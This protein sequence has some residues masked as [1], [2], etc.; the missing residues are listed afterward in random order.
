MATIAVQ[1]PGTT[2]NNR[3]S[4]RPLSVVPPAART[5]AR[6]RLSRRGR[7]LAVVVLALALLAGV[8]LGR[9]AISAEPSGATAAPSTT[10]VQP[11]DTLWSLSRRVAPDHDPRQV[12]LSLQQL[13]GLPGGEI[14]PGQVLILPR[15]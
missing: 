5:E 2:H 11:G 9:V 1:H 8:S 6:L 7:F 12:V 13:N 3:R 14:R 15:H 4:A 10:V